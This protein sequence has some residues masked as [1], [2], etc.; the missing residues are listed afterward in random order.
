MGN[1]GVC[2]LNPR[3]VQLLKPLRCGLLG[4]WWAG[5]GAQE[6]SLMEFIWACVSP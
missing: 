5:P 3:V 2:G 1:L 4:E 6:V